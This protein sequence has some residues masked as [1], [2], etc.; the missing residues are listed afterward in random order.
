MRHSV[1]PVDMLPLLDVIMVVLFAFATIQEVQL[2]SSEDAIAQA[3][4]G[5]ASAV[6]A[7]AALSAELAVAQQQV[8]ELKQVQEDDIDDRWSD[9]VLSHLLDVSHVVEIEL[10][11]HTVEGAVGG[12]VNVC[13]F[14]TDPRGGAWETCGLVPVGGAARAEW[15]RDDGAGLREALQATPD[16]SALAIVRQ[17][18]RTTYKI[19]ERVRDLLRAQMEDRKTYVEELATPMEASCAAKLPG[20]AAPKPENTTT[21]NEER[22]Q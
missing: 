21:G 19:G 10:T 6:S 2:E 16:G 3:Q 12:L 4:E 9:S 22:T 18:P 15:M 17:G 20:G 7:L 1:T 8:A 14:R 11:G 13:C 5:Q